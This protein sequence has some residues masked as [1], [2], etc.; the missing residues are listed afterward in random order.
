MRTI[1]RRDDG[2]EYEEWLEQ[3]ARASGIETPTREDLAKLD[4]KCPKKGLNKDW[5]HPHYPEARITKMK[6]GRTPGSG[7]AHGG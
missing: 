5:E 6:D 7:L 4:R 3:L 2:T 1:V